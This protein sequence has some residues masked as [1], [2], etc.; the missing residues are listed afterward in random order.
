[1]WLHMSEVGAIL[2]AP[3]MFYMQLR[4]S[5]EILLCQLR[6]IVRKIPILFFARSKN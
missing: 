3:E 2:E 6:E 4:V 5:A 1:M